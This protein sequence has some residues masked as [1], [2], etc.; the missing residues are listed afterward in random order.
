[1]DITLTE[2]FHPVAVAL[3]EESSKF[4]WV[5][6]PLKLQPP[7]TIR[8]PPGQLALTSTSLGRG[9]PLIKA[10]WEIRSTLM[11]PI[12]RHTPDWQLDLFG[13]CDP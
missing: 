6:Y 1:M 3:G 11:I 8:F 13:N 2:Q 4:T 7:L 10:Y 12:I 5:E 9:S